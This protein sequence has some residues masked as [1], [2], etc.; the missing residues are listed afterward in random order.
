VCVIIIVVNAIITIVV[1]IYHFYYCH[2]D[3]AADVT[4][5]VQPDPNGH[6]KVMTLSKIAGVP[7]FPADATAEITLPS[8]FSEE[9]FMWGVR[10]AGFKKFIEELRIKDPGIFGVS[11]IKVKTADGQVSSAELLKLTNFSR[12]VCERVISGQERA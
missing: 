11:E 12:S 5:K 9:E 1:V 7:N 8:T 2:F 10:N 4:V 6:L 3:G